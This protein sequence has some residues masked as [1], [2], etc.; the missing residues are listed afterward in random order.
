V[1]V[2]SFRVDGQVALI[3]GGNRG[4]GPGCAIALA[5]AGADVVLVGRAEPTDTAKEI[6]ALGRRVTYVSCDLAEGRG[7]RDRPP[8]VVTEETTFDQ[9]KAKEVLPLVFTPRA[10]AWATR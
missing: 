9:A 8:R 1:I 7:G 5:E 10:S 4:L 6:A 3:T 2:D